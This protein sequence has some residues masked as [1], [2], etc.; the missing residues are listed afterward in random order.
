MVSGAVVGMNS[1]LE[2]TYLKDEMTCQDSDM[3]VVVVFI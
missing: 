1:L 3:D 2:S